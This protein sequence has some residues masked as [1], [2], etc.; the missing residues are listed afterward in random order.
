MPPGKGKKQVVCRPLLFLP[1]SH[2]PLQRGDCGEILCP[3]PCPS[4]VA[5]RKGAKRG[6]AV[7]KKGLLASWW[8]CVIS[9]GGGWLAGWLQVKGSS[10]GRAAYLVDWASSWKGELRCCWAGGEEKKPESAPKALRGELGW[11][12]GLLFV[13]PHCRHGSG[14]LPCRHRGLGRHHPPLPGVIFAG[15]IFAGSIGGAQEDGR[16]SS[17]FLGGGGGGGIVAVPDELVELGVTGYVAPNHYCPKPP[18]AI[19]SL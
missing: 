14:L 9:L 2:L 10:V 12:F 15:S 18:L 17:L 16:T 8:R 1:P 13:G 6:G 4:A 5:E 11:C 19:F 7:R 3:C